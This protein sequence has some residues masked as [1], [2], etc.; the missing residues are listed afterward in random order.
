MATTTNGTAVPKRGPVSKANK[1][2]AARVYIAAS[3]KSGQPVPDWI[4]TIAREGAA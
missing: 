1:A 3:K 2:A 4:K